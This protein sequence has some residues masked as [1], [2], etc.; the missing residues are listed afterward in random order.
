MGLLRQG[1]AWLGIGLASVLRADSPRL[2]EVG[3]FPTPREVRTQIEAMERSPFD[4]T[5]IRIPLPQDPL[6]GL[7]VHLLGSER[8]PP[9]AVKASLEDLRATQFYRMKENFLHVSLSPP[10][11]DWQRFPPSAEANFRL[12]AGLARQ[13]GLRGLFLDLEAP[14][15]AMFRPGS[16]FPF[17]A[18]QARALGER[19]GRIWAETFPQGVLL[20]SS[21]YEKVQ[22]EVEAGFPLE[23]SPWGLL[24]FF[25]DGLLSALPEEARVVHGGCYGFGCRRREEFLE[26]LFR[27]LRFLP[28]VS[29]LGRRLYGRLE[30]GL[31]LR[32]DFEAEVRGWEGSDWSRNYYSPKDW[33]EALTAALRWGEGYVLVLSR[34]GHLPAVY[35]E[36]TR[37]AKERAL[38][39]PSHPPS[40]RAAE[41]PGYDDESTF[42]DLKPWYEEVL[43]LPSEW[44]LAFDAQDRGVQERWFAPDYD[45]LGWRKVRIG[46][47]WE[48]QGYDYDGVAWYRVAFTVPEALRGRIVRLFF[49]AVDDAAWVFVNGQ[50]AG[51]HDEGGRRRFSVE[52]THLLRFD[53]PNLLVVRVLDRGGPGG[54]WKSVKLMAERERP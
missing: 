13:A 51:I 47:F 12:A 37:R 28:Q 34:Q 14:S 21:A 40:P 15:S 22:R 16:D 30:M 24:P 39:G 43:S 18:Q 33:E 17:C 3:T 19:W 45:A 4:G 31:G 27:V 49:G 54:I 48:E 20:L 44:V 11:W 50:L 5:V 41:M 25:L 36:A 53:A 35:L 38:G 23:A 8:I 26:R 32:L 46:A 52:V 29:R 10:S 2:I 9:E 6:R 42:G 7:G 1:W